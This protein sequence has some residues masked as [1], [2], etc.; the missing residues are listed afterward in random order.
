MRQDDVSK[1]MREFLSLCRRYRSD[2]NQI[3]KFEDIY[4]NK[5]IDY[6]KG[7]FN[8]KDAHDLQMLLGGI[9]KEKEN[10]IDGRTQTFTLLK[11]VQAIHSHELP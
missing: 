1:V 8:S 3:L 5:V 4:K 7:V 2:L 10:V 9:R 11:E 6:L